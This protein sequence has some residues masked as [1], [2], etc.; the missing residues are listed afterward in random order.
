MGC[1]F[2]AIAGGDIP[3]AELWQDAH[4]FAFLDINPLRPGHALV[5]PKRH[6]THHAQL[7]PSERQALWDAV[8]CLT[9]VVSAAVGATDAT[10]A[11]NDGPAAGQEVPHCHV[12]I[13]PRRP[14]DGGGP[15]H[16]LFPKGAKADVEELHDL[17]LRVQAAL[18]GGGP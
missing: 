7:A 17:A 16:A 8:A 5:V 4:A 3:S 12:H 13:V 14:G 6:H 18:P 2:C 9:P 15:I 1:L 10:I 11:I